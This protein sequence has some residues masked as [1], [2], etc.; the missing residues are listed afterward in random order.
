VFNCLSDSLLRLAYQSKPLTFFGTHHVQDNGDIFYESLR[1]DFDC[2]LDE[3]KKLISNAIFNSRSKSKFEWVKFDYAL[4]NS[5][6]K[7]A[8]SRNL[9]THSGFDI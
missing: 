5:M 6:L 8:S 4:Q 7:E 1:I 9:T 3:T 2:S